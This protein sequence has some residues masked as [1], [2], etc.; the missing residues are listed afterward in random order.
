[1]RKIFSNLLKRINL[2]KKN[3]KPFLIFLVVA[4]VLF[5]L[6]VATPFLST[7]GPILFTIIFGFFLLFISVIAGYAVFR[8]LLAASIGLSLIIFIGQSY[9][10]LPIN[11][12]VANTSLVTLIS[13]G[14]IYV[15][16]QFIYSLYKE[17][18]GDKEAKEEWRRNGIITLFKEANSNKHSWFALFIYA[19]FIALFIS[20]IYSVINPIIHGLCV[21]K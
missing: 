15:S 17:L 5:V 4:I 2:D 14:F 11:E 19:L 7:I 16:V 21:Y 18:F 1:M 13:I 3:I 8:S 12:Q 20:Q 6:F 9:C 10:S